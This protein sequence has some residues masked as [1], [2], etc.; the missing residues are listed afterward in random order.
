MLYA[1]GVDLVDIPSGYNHEHQ[2]IAPYNSRQVQMAKEVKAALVADGVWANTVVDDM[3]VD[4][5]FAARAFLR[6][7]SEEKL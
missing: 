6:D 1:H 4:A 3:A 5:V 2:K 7:Q